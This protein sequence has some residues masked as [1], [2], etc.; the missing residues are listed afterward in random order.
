MLIT[1]GP[2]FTAA[3]VE[4]S[5]RMVQYGV[6]VNGFGCQNRTDD[7]PGIYTNV[8]YYIEWVLDKMNE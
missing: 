1:G 7:Y 8:G 2:L 5:V 4:G 6:F 3:E